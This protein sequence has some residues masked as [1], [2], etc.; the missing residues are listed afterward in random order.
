MWRYDAARSATSPAGLDADLQLHWVRQYPALSPA[1][2]DP[3]NQDRMPYDRVYE[4]VVLGQMMF[5][6]SSS[7]DSLTAL[8]TRTGRRLWRFFADGPVR[9]PAVAWGGKVYFASDDGYLYCLNAVKGTLVWKFRGGPIDRRVLGNGRLISTWPARGGPVI[10]DGTVYF[11]AGIWPFMGV[12]IHALDAETGRVIWTNDGQSSSYIKQ[13]HRALSFAGVAPQGSLVV[14]GDKLLV[15]GGRSVPA[16]LDRKTGKL[17]YYHLSSSKREGGSH[18]SAVGKFFFNHRGINTYMYKLDSGSRYALW[19]IDA[20]YWDER[21]GNARYPVLD[22]EMCYLAGN[23]LVAY[24]LASLRRIKV[25]ERRINRRTKKVEFVERNPWTMDRPWEFE[26]DGTGAMIKAGSRLY[27]GGKDVISAVEIVDGQPPKLLWSHPVKG[28][29]GRI[30]AADD[31]LFAVTREGNVY[32][33]GP[34]ERKLR[35]YTRT[36]EPL[37]PKDEIAVRRTDYLLEK[38]NIREGYCVLYGA[39]GGNLAAELLRRTKLKII[40]VEPDPASVDNLRRKFSKAGLYGDRISIHQGDVS[41]FRLPPYLASLVQINPGSATGGLADQSLAEVIY[42][43]LRP[44]GG[45][46][47][48]PY[49]TDASRL[50]TAKLPGSEVTILDDSVR[51]NR[52]GALPGSADWTHQYGNVANTSKSDDSVVRA[53]LGLLWFG[54]NSNH[55]VLPRHGHGPPEQVL[56]G[57]LFIQG[58]NMLSARDVYTGRVLWKRKFDDLGTAGVYYNDTY[59]ADPLDTTYN[60]KHIPGANARGTNYIVTEDKIY[61]VIGGDC[62][63]LDPATGKTIGKITLPGDSDNENDEND[64]KPTW[65]YIGVYE[66]LLIA[67]ADFSTHVASSG[68][69]FH[70]S[71]S[72]DQMSSRRLIVM[73]RHSGKVIWQRTATNAFSH[74][75][76]IAGADKLFCVDAVPT[77]LAAIM[78]RRGKTVENS[79]RLI[80]MDVRSGKVLWAK[81]E[82]VFGTWLGYSQ[83]HDVLVQ[84]GRPSSDM[85]SE[86]DKRMV[87]YRGASGRVLWNKK[88]APSD[89]KL[90]GPAML[91]GETIF[92]NA[93]RKEGWAISLL[94]GE[95]KQ[96]THPLTGEKVPWRY[97]REYGCNSVTASEYL[98]TFRSGAAGF[99]DLN[100]DAGTG[101]LGGFKSGCTSN[102]IAANGVLNAPDYTRTCTCPY[103]NQTS[104]AMIHDP[105][106]EV[107]TF[108]RLEW[109][110]KPIRR[111]GVNLGAP[112]DRMS[113]DGTLWLDYPSVGGPSPDVAIRVEGIDGKKLRWFR[114]HSSR[115]VKGELKYVTASGVEGIGSITIPLVKEDSTAGPV[116]ERFYKVRLLMAEPEPT[117]FGTRTFDVIIPGRASRHSVDPAVLAG[118]GKRTAVVVFPSVKAGKELTI[119]FR[120]RTGLPLLCGVEV[121]AK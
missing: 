17:L 93:I 75:S 10:A 71:E 2:V 54:G 59:V 14:A 25:S 57:R 121:I 112:G 60:Q 78:T 53:P 108:N 68:L 79:P 35:M 3:V 56:G 46:A 24:D 28:T 80:A 1:W 91:H 105:D 61:L 109:S 50:S 12:F 18:V 20:N 69:K 29:V 118:G 13:P 7:T 82:K 42:P 106:V 41:T 104:L 6:G 107:W 96:R 45:V 64:K 95:E 39:E 116:V 8:D 31:R 21:W 92:L 102:L 38:Y 101:N 34:G 58:I 87:A 86:P 32:A 88:V 19:D 73:D 113:D 65:T 99:Y 76:I 62:L 52:V 97:Q 83:E 9:V 90:G 110:G 26:V 55:D 48:M 27:V 98:L 120:A 114:H 117:R 84:G 70:W 66:D 33:F 47:L 40:L 115:I 119:Q 44:Y 16:C 36:V 37:P 72:Y 63:L 74:N 94:T 11:A 23:P 89:M 4:P 111:I 5:I 15:P 22:G 77:E 43:S 49:G 81:S 51:L 100:A 67:G 85:V 30:I 103:Q